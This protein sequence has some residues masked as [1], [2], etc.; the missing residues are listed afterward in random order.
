MKKLSL[1]LVVALAMLVAMT[2]VVM[3]T[4]TGTTEITGLPV[5]PSIN[6]TTPGPFSWD[7]DKSSSNA[8]EKEISVG[9]TTAG[10]SSWSLSVSDLNGGLNT[11]KMRYGGDWTIALVNPVYAYGG[12]FYPLVDSGNS[13]SIVV[14]SG[15]SNVVGG[16]F[17]VILRQPMDSTDRTD[18]TYSITLLFTGSA[19]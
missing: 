12:G 18:L 10:S 2:G 17:P 14:A 9:I 5:T 3:A 15:S 8:N 11:G 13:Q 4:P 1:M 19:L 7:L 6:V 16:S